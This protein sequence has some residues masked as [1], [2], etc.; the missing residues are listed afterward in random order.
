MQVIDYRTTRFVMAPKTLVTDAEVTHRDKCVYLALAMYANN[1]T[2]AARPSTQTI[3]DN[4]GCSRRSVFESIKRLEQNGYI[5]RK[6]RS[7]KKSGSLSNIYY[8]LDKPG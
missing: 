7:S 1:T 8:L 6:R 2:K 5:K 4:V 3:A